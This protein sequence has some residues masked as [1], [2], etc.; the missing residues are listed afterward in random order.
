MEEAT[1]TS[2]QVSNLRSFGG[3]AVDAGA[4]DAGGLA[5]F[6]RH[7][8]DLLSELPGGSQNQTLARETVQKTKPPGSVQ[9]ASQR[10]ILVV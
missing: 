7:L 1:L 5:I 10:F 4:L 6:V 3:A 2:L 8:L 9:T